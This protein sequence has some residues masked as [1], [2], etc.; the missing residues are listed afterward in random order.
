MFPRLKVQAQGKSDNRE[1]AWNAKSSRPVVGK[2]VVKN[3]S[4]IIK[5]N[6]KA[7]FKGRISAALN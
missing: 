5:M 7:L 2:S 3:D 6:P 1:A 4:K